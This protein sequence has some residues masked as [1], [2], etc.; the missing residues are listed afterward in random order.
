MLEELIQLQNRFQ[1]FLRNRDYTFIG[2]EDQSLLE[3]F[4]RRANDLAPIVSIAREIRHFLNNREAAI[5]ALGALPADTQLRIYVV[6]GRSDDIL[7][8]DTIEN[9]CANNKIE[10]VI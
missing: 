4:M 2:P 10:F 9:Y 5:Q 6:D 7:L 1:P 8:L 3:P